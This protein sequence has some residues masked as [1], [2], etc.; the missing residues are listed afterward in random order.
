MEAAAKLGGTDFAQI[1]A[2]SSMPSNAI[3]GFALFMSPTAVFTMTIAA[4]I[5]ALTTPA[6][7]AGGVYAAATAS[8]GAAT[9]TQ[10]FTTTLT[11]MSASK[12]LLVTAAIIAVACVP[13]GYQLPPAVGYLHILALVATLCRC[14]ESKSSFLQLLESQ[15]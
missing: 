13:I 3:G 14:E 7:V 15:V 9:A 10:S 4:A 2:Y 11:A 6:A 1:L 5:G 12:P 8:A